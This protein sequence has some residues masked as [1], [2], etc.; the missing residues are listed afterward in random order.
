MIRVAHVMSGLDDLVH[1]VAGREVERSF[2]VVKAKVSGFWV[3][4]WGHA[5]HGR[6]LTDIDLVRHGARDRRGLAREESR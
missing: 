3:L 5:G 4:L 2:R 1:G 6:E